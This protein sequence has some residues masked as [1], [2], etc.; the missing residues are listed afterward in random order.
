MK[1][2]EPEDGA[3]MREKLSRQLEFGLSLYSTYEEL[4]R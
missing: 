3:A 1:D 2:M 4:K